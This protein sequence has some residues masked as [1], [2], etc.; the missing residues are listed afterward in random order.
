MDFFYTPQNGEDYKTMV[1]RIS[2]FIYDRCKDDKDILVFTHNGVFRVMK[3]LLTGI[4]LSEVFN[5][6]EPFLEPQSFDVDYELLCKIRIN[7]FYTVEE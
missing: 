5:E 6:F 2:E 7:P 4:P 1:M 3:S